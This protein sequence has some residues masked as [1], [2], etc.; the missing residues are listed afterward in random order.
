[1]DLSG[2]IV[3]PHK[4]SSTLDWWIVHIEC[5]DYKCALGAKFHIGSL[6]GEN[7]LYKWL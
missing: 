3:T 4:V 2:G 5:M 1:M 7:G 6:I